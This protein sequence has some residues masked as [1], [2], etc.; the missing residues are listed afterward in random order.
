M[1]TV[2]QTN[3]LRS[4]ALFYQPCST[5]LDYMN[6]S[7]NDYIRTVQSVVPEYAQRVQQ[8][9]DEICNSAAVQRI[10]NIKNRLNSVWETDTIR[11]LNTIEK[12]QNAPNSMR[13]WVM[14]EPSLRD[15]YLEGCVSA[16]DNQYVD[17]NPKDGS[18]KNH[19]DYRRVTNGVV[20]EASNGTHYHNNYIE[21]IKDP[22]D[23]LTVY[24]QAAIL[25]TWQVIKNSLESD[26]NRDPTGL[27]NETL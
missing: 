21:A 20:L 5:T 18:G 25:S 4:D 1:A 11:S 24:Q 7:V 15:R 8:R 17:L 12:I 27:Y 6:Q 10:A 13:R 26:D 23:I 3:N 16:Y 9:Y 2:I 14:A 22:S 19:Y